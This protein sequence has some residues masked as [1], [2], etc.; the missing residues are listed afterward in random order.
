MSFHLQL[1]PKITYGIG[2]VVHPPKKID[3]CFQSILYLALS[4]LGVNRCITKFWR[5][6]P[7]KYQ[8]LGLPDFV[9]LSC[10]AK[11]S[12]MLRHWGFDDAAGKAMMQAYEAFV[13]ESGLYGDIFSQSFKHLGVLTTEGTWFR[14]LW[15]TLQYLGADLMV[16]KEYHLKPLCSGDASIMATL[17]AKGYRGATFGRLCRVAHYKGVVHLSDLVNCDGR[18]FADDVLDDSPGCS[19]KHKFPRE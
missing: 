1:T 17:S 6:L 3:T 18:S 2:A 7:I 19:M 14:N 16:S 12:F 11:V 13:M 9:S 10:A 5:T 15:E 4:F 8:G